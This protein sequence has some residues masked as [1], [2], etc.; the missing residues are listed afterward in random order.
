M[1]VRPSPDGTITTRTVTIRA[2]NNEQGAALIETLPT[3]AV[4]VQLADMPEEES[5]ERLDIVSAERVAEVLAAMAE[6]VAAKIVGSMRET[7]AAAAL[8]AM[9]P[10]RAAAILTRVR[11]DRRS[12]V[13][14]SLTPERAAAIFAAIPD[15]VSFFG[16]LKVSAQVIARFLTVMPFDDV[17]RILTLNTTTRQ[18]I[19][20][21]LSEISPQLAARLLT[22]VDP[23]VAAAWLSPCTP[24]AFNAIVDELTEEPVTG[25][26]LAI[27]HELRPAANGVLERLGEERLVCL[28]EQTS[29]QEIG[30]WLHPL[31]S[32]GMRN[33]G[34]SRLRAAMRR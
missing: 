29:P 23:H 31:Q 30:D 21:W 15:V 6:N 25:K 7:A 5:A 20:E 3:D 34:Y 4:L 11:R 26:F 24:A 14:T 10:A 33:P 1:A 8:D 13:V 2:V 18:K 32:A 16:E 27:L 28:L 12:V 22:A 19:P 9:E 17:L